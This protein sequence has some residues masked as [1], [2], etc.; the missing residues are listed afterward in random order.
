MW[1]IGPAKITTITDTTALIISAK[2]KAV[3]TVLLSVFLSFV[4]LHFAVI[5]ETM[6]GI[7][8]DTS[9]KSTMKTEKLI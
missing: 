4:A 3:V 9:V 7:P 2:I 8:L 1:E 6:S 5:L